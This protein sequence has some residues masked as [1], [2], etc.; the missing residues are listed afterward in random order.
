MKRV[1]IIVCT[2]L[3]FVGFAK[4]QEG[5]NTAYFLS[6]SPQQYRLNP[7]YQPEYKVFIGL[8]ALSGISINYLNSSFKVDDLLR[9]RDDSVYFDVNRLYKSLRKRNFISLDN[10][11]SI[12]SVGVKANSWYMT[13]DLSERNDFL[14]RVNK[15]L[16]T[17]VKNGNSDYLGKTMDFG[18]LGLNGN[19]YVELALGLS[20]KVN[21][22]LTVGAR[23]KY[24]LGIAN[25]NMTDSEMSVTTEQ[26]GEYMEL[27]S[28]Q[29]IRVSA[30]VNITDKQTGKPFQPGHYIDWDDF[31]VDTDNLDVSSFLNA[32][33]SGFALDFGGE[34]QFN[35]KI[36]LFASLTDLGFIH[37]GANI[38]NFSQDTRFRW[39]GADV[40]NSINKQDP[41]Y[42][43]MDDA[44]DDLLDN[45]KDSFRL[46][47]SG[48][49][50]TTMLSPKLY[51]GATYDLNKMFNVGGL[52]KATL[53]DGMFYPSLTASANARLLRNVSASVS[54]SI[55]PGNYVNVGAGLTAKLGPVQLYVTTDNLL[56]ANY[57]HTQAVS[58]R[59]GINLLFGHKDKKRKSKK[60]EEIL[61]ETAVVIAPVPMKKDTV[62][63]DT[64]APLPPLKEEKIIRSAD[65]SIKAYHV[66]VGSFKNKKSAE[67][68][69]K[70]LVFMGFKESSVLQNEAGLYR[71][72][73][74]SY[75]THAGC[76]E[77]VFRIRKKYP[78]YVDAWGLTAK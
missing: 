45:L 74:A 1:I 65:D 50:Y 16:F 64:V 57:T 51:L 7:A 75:D 39:D 71:V 9:K 8:P 20:K 17:F 46:Q 58:A 15:D 2:V 18:K 48:K 41:N 37:W 31:D 62:Q 43:S 40:S 14:F 19:A 69:K 26:N 73:A 36:K 44:F 30:P 42:N 6:N 34:Y 49:A 3:S 29:K 27:Y 23:A 32:K 35:D 11:N 24:L 70:H 38:H 63:E 76:W 61:P 55:M 12:L 47:E 53:N 59:F 28:K 72:C 5:N 56:A 68:L 54:Y 4:A 10:Q 60:A 22:K 66:V 33:N 21:N 77:E 52:F 78:Q 25:V 67:A 13:F